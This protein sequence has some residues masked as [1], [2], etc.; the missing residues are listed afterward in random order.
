MRLPYSK[1]VTLQAIKVNIY[2]YRYFHLDTWRFMSHYYNNSYF[3]SSAFLH[4]NSKYLFS[5]KY[6]EI[7]V[8]QANFTI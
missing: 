6:W 3:K 2:F 1:K 7:S 8:G 4:S 5:F